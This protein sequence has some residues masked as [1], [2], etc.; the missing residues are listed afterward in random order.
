VALIKI[1]THVVVV[2]VRTWYPRSVRSFGGRPVRRP[3]T[4]NGL[5]IGA[6]MLKKRPNR[7]A[8]HSNESAERVAS[9]RMRLRLMPRKSRSDPEAE[10]RHHP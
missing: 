4:Q 2:V 6:R 7:G 5:A 1:S 3:E 10:G 8:V 9:A